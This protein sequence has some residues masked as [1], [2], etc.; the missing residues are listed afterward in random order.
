ML[1]SM[2][3]GAQALSPKALRN[4]VMALVS[5]S[6]VTT[7]PDQIDVKSR[8]IVGPGSTAADQVA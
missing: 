6:S 4:L 8:L 3:C 1:V 5:A 2:T 7:R